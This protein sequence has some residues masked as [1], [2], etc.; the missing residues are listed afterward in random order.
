MLILDRVAKGV[1][2]LPGIARVQ[3]ITRPLG[4]PIDHSSVPFQVSM[5][6]ST[7]IENMDFL[8]AR[9]AD[10]LKTSDEL[11]KVITSAE[12]L[13]ALTQQLAVITHDLDGRSH[14]LVTD[15]NS[16]RD[17]LAD[18]DDVFRPLRNY[19]YWEPHCYDIPMCASLRSLFDSLDGIE[20]LSD[21]L[22][23]LTSADLDQLDS[24]LPK[25]SAE[26]PPIIESTKT[27]RGYLVTTY[28]TFNGLINQT[29][30]MVEG[31][32][33]MGQAFD[34]SK[35]DDSFYLPP[36]AFDNPDFKRGLK[37]LVSP[38]GKSAENIITTR[39]IRLRRKAFHTLTRL[40]KPPT[41]R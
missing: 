18:F 31:S 23:G 24:V 16:V 8:K 5:Q 41:R 25:L 21:D 1:F 30:K 35:N 11:A 34:A 2:H 26:L 29:D 17:H 7:M 28:S 6:S 40:G 14:D 4:S 38:D 13:Y 27:L 12:N 36:E 20:K 37:L 9:M 3:S 33:V 10:L 19:F 22:Q 32:T 39:G 15:T